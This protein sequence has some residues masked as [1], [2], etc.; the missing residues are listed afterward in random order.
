MNPSNYLQTKVR[1]YPVALQ[2]SIGEVST[3]VITAATEIGHNK[4]PEFKFKTNK[5]IPKGI[6]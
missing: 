2:I 6:G 3:Y 1:P 5:K 4:P